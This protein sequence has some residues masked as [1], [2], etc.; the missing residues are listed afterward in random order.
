MANAGFAG[1]L[2]LDVH[3]PMA[4]SLKDKRAHLRSIT[5]SLRRAGFSASE[6]AHHDKWQRSELA[7]SVVGR[8]S[9]D[10]E[11]RLDEALAISERIGCEATI[12]QR[13]VL[14]LDDFDA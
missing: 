5:A 11:R 13:H 6:T 1:L 12:R 3:F 2:V 9:N 14:G 7:I 4:Q 10:V 8:A